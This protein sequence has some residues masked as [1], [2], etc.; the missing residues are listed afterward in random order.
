MSGIASPSR[1]GFV[2]VD[3]CRS[4]EKLFISISGLIGAGK[5]TL[6]DALGKTMEIPV[7]H[8]P[9]SDNIYLEDFYK[10]PSKF[11]F[12]MQIYL[13]NAR[14]QQ[15][16]QIIWTGQGGV[17]DRT[18]YEDSVFAKMLNK[19]GLMDDRDYA[20]YLSL[21]GHM[22]NFMKKPNL[23]VHLDVSPEVSLERVKQRARE[24]E[25]GSESALSLEYLTNLHNAYQEF[26]E[27]IS[28]VIPVIR[29]NWNEFRDADEMAEMIQ[30]EW[31]TMQ[32]IRVVDF[33]DTPRTLRKHRAVEESEVEKLPCDEAAK[34]EIDSP[35]KSEAA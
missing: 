26:I 21:F 24:C 17:Q 6:C 15:H 19:S 14:F 25:N 8:E 32:Q 22:S 34:P 33:A 18:I 29:V 30:K 2:G 9:V 7:F 13:L 35:P 12:P 16:Q 11:G 1:S 27:E 5:T 3:S 23:I 4:C 10:D 20:T 28:K 31:S